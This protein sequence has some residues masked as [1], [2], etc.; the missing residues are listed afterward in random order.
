M[1]HDLAHCKQLT[2]RARQR[3]QA[4]VYGLF[5]LAG[6]LAAL[7]FLFNSGQ[8]TLEKSKLVDTADA[9]AYSA[10]VM[11]A[12][13]LNFE[14][15]TNR[16]M[17]ANTVVIA[18]MVSMASWA[19][20]A[21]TFGQ[22]GWAARNWKYLPEIPPAYL[23]ASYSSQ[24][25]GSTR[26]N[27]AF[28]ATAGASD[29]IIT[30]LQAAQT[31]AY[32]GL[33]PARKAV[34]DA[35][36]QANWQN[37]GTVVV[38]LVPLTGNEFNSF[39]SRYS[40]NDR[41][42]FADTAKTAADLDKFVPKRSWLR[43]GARS[44][45]AAAT[46]TGRVDFLT[47]RGGTELIGF[48]EWKA[49]DTLEE[50]RWVP[51]NKADPLCSALAID[52]LGWGEQNAGEQSASL[53]PTRYDQSLLINPGATLMAEGFSSSSWSYS[54]I[55]SFY[56]LSAD[57]LDQ[58]DP[59]LKFAIRVRRDK[60]ETRTS[61][62]RA[63]VQS[64]PAARSNPNAPGLNQYRATPAPG[65]DNREEFVAVSAN[66][67]FFARPDGSKDNVYGSG[68][69]KPREIGSLFNPYWQTHLIYSDADVKKAQAL[70][71]MGNVLP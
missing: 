58:D 23:A 42:R 36:A 46:A 5:V 71:L 29:D 67:V 56:D 63:Q 50:K 55:P 49:V 31:V 16:A 34:M 27:R 45:C 60:S 7:F 57:A 4:L 12:R 11:H 68:L 40:D 62:A 10:G 59:R 70:Q 53:D 66:E 32:A 20:Y 35:V 21:S 37:D 51:R 25:L 15:Y 61:E 28:E 64:A 17:I 9:V 41:T 39:V 48:N 2:S 14:A 52:P 65:P 8:L 44:D 26:V 54:G 38:D 33:I 24:Y 18:Q 43:P 47:R 3:G 30:A 1:R 6:G 19:K 69:G 13:T 22:Y